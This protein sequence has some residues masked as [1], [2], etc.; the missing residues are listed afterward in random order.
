MATRHTFR[1]IFASEARRSAVIAIALICWTAAASAQ[2]LTPRAYWPA[3]KGTRIAVAGYAHI[4]G[5]ILFDPSVPLYEV[6][7]RVNTALVGYLQTCSLF[8]RSSNVLIK[9]PYIWGR[10]EGLVETTPESRKFSNFADLGVTLAINLIGAPSMTVEDF[11]AFRAEPQPILGM[12]VEV[13]APTGNYSGSRLI[14]EGGNRWGIKP[15]FGFMYPLTKKLLFEIEAGAWFFEDDDRFVG[16]RKE[17]APIFTSEIHLIRRFS[18][19]FW[20]SLDWTYYTGGRQ[21]I[22][23]NELSDDQSNSR[24]GATLVKPLSRRQVIKL[25]YATGLKTRFSIDFDQFLLSYQVL[26]N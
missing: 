5:N 22:G 19:G 9:L 10:T 14:N 17:Q 7:S 20:M 4:D 18:P 26:L 11:Q 12:S 23:G 1:T 13:L 25:G 15:E 6:E 16:G 8:G 3:P 21:T 2:E 24:I